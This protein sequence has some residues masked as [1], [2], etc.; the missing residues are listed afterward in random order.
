MYIH[1][2]TRGR[3]TQI[4]NG[5]ASP[6]LSIGLLGVLILYTHR[7]SLSQQPNLPPRPARTLSP[8]VASRMQY[9]RDL[10]D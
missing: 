7:L 6:L 3:F 2:W 5:L 10:L 4:T 1:T 9:P 8:L